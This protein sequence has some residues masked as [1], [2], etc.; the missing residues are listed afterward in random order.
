M[1]DRKEFMERA[2]KLVQNVSTNPAAI[3]WPQDQWGFTT[4]L[5]KELTSAARRVVGQDDKHD[6]LIATLS[7]ALAHVRKR[8]EVDAV[9]AAEKLVAHEAARQG[10]EAREQFV[11][12]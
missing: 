7:V 8:K 1:Y 2:Q 5:R 9:A 6:L 10:R 4:G 12:D 3:E 11:A